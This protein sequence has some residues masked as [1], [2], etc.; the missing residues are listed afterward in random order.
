MLFANA[1]CQAPLCNPSRTSVLTGLRPSTTGVYALEPWFRVVPELKDHVTLPQHF[2][3]NGYITLSSGKI[4]H[5]GYPSKEGRNAEFDV[6]GV[7]SGV[8]AKPKQKL[9]TTPEGNHP[10]VDWGTFPHRDE[11]K[12]DWQQASWTVE[13]LQ[14]LARK[15]GQPFFLA[16]GFFLPHVPCYATQ[17]WFDLYPLETLAM[18]TVPTFD[19]A[20]VPAFSWYLHWKLPEPRLSWLK[21]EQQWAPLVQAYLASVSFVDSQV[22]RVLDGLEQSGLANNTLVV[23]W[24]DHGWHLGEKGMTGKTSLW[25]ESTRVPLIFAGP[26]VAQG[27]CQEPVELLDLYPT[28]A[29]VCGLPAPPRVEGI[30]LR[31]QL[32]NAQAPRARPAVITESPGNHAVVTNQWRLIRYADGSRELYDFR[33]DPSEWTNLIDDPQYAPAASELLHWIP[34]SDA[35]P[36]PGSKSRLL[37]RVGDGDQWLWEGEPIRPEELVE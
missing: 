16:V 15:P 17:K 27:V 33:A 32:E 20:D 26:G 11:D 21:Q 14:Q 18:P 3:R 12:G 36:A 37:I 6:W 34:A 28:L 5:G 22:G 35:P 7:P 8:G 10:L 19:R 23:L 30:S 29:G 1:H 31:P 4:Y 13:Q 2:K 9:V 25:R 24:S